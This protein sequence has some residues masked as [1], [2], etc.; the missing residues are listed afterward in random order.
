[1]GGLRP[2][3]KQSGMIPNG[4]YY[5]NATT[6][7]FIL[8]YKKFSTFIPSNF[9][10]DTI[11]HKLHCKNEPMI[12]PKE[13]GMSCVHPSRLHRSYQDYLIWSLLKTPPP[14]RPCLNLHFLLALPEQM[15]P[16][17]ISVPDVQL[18]DLLLLD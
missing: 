18:Q 8:S 2:E 15:I 6:L 5:Y 3:S 10:I 7:H 11:K 9:S 1:M 14:R 4:K 13:G 16:L 12:Q 17:L